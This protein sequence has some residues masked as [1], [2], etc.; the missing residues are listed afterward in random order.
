MPAEPS[1]ED[2]VI[3][4]FGPRAA[5]YVASSVHARGPDLDRIEAV[6]RELR[7]G[8]ALDLGAGGGHVSYRLAPHCGEVVACDLSAEM[9]AAVLATARERGLANV[10]GAVAPAEALPFATASF[11]FLACRMSA[12]HW[13]DWEAGLREARRVLRPGGRA[14]FVDVIAPEQPL[15]DTHLQAIELLRDGSHVRDHR[16]SEWLAALGRAGFALRAAATHR[17]RMDFTDWIGRMDPPECHV[18]AIRSLQTLAA[19]AV[20]TTLAVEPNGSFS[21]DVVT[22][23]LA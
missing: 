20:K 5:A 17:L 11:D 7:P 2:R 14:L 3:A 9:V 18:A 22:F 6:A 16:A 19:D 4:Q 21:F 23:D 12:H 1:H 10:T 13:R 8:R 15:A